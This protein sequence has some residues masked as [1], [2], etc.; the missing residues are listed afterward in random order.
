MELADDIDDGIFY[1][2]SYG[3]N[4]VFRPSSSSPVVPVRDDIILFDPLVDTVEFNKTFSLDPSISSELQHHIKSIVIKYWD[5]FCKR[6]VHRHILSF[7]FG[8]DTGT[9][10]PMSCSNQSY[11][12]HEA[13]IIMEQIVNLLK[14][15]W[16]EE[17]LGPW[18]SK[19][20]LTPKPHQEHVN[21]I[22]FHLVHV[23]LLSCTKRC[24]QTICISNELLR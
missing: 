21:D 14:N 5:C 24:H 15:D 7:E 2:T 20:V 16:V 3:G 13:R 23:R 6:G 17:C 4:C 9:A 10:E 11:G 12:F 22:D 19:I 18:A 8:I 1:Y